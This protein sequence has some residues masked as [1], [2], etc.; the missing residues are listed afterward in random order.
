M[1]PSRGE[2]AFTLVELLVAITILGVISVPLSM[3]F[4]TGMRALGR[5]D[6]MF[7]DSRSALIAANYFAADVAGANAVVV[8][9]A[10]ACGGGSAVVSFDSSDAS[11]GVSAAVN[12]EVSYVFDS[13]DP[14]NDKLLRKYCPNGG[15]QQTQSTTSVALAAAPVV[16]CYDAGNVVNASCSKPRWVKLAVTQKTN[17]ATPDNPT[18]VAYTFTLEGTRRPT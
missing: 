13:T 14:T 18:P 16:T 10:S 12:N 7:N 9:D 11:L 5:S 15:A 2:R 3:A 4:I 6:E 8:N 17:R 1:T